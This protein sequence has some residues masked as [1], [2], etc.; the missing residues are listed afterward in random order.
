MVSTKQF[1]K[2]VVF[3]LLVFVI[4]FAVIDKKRMNE[5]RSQTETSNK[6]GS[7]NVTDQQSPFITIEKKETI[8]IG[9]EYE[10]T[11]GIISDDTTLEEVYGGD[12]NYLWITEDMLIGSWSKNVESLDKLYET[13]DP[14]I[15]EFYYAADGLIHFYDYGLRKDLNFSTADRQKYN[16][17]EWSYGCLV[18]WE[19]PIAKFTP[20]SDSNIFFWDLSDID[21]G[22]IVFH[23]TYSTVS[24]HKISDGRVCESIT[25]EFY[26]DKEGNILPIE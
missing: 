11:N 10:E 7:T 17:W 22:I 16:I 25:S 2:V 18:S 12:E 14:D 15:I 8:S 9:A 24:F 5:Y 20:S 6:A 23:D 19:P 21:K 1:L 3:V 4:V 13:K 26:T